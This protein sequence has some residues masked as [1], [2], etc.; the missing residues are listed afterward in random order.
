MTTA[1]DLTTAVR[2]LAPGESWPN[3]KAAAQLLA[4]MDTRPLAQPLEVTR[5]VPAPQLGGRV[6]IDAYGRQRRGIVVAVF[7]TKVLVAYVAPS[8]PDVI[9][10]ARVEFAAATAEPAR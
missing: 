10:T 9:K 6:W 5:D 4:V 7:R 2:R 1:T 8:S 3:T